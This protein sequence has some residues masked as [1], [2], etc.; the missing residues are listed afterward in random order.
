MEILHPSEDLLKLKKQ[1]TQRLQ[2]FPE[3]GSCTPIYKLPKYMEAVGTEKR[4][5]QTTET[6]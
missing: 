2:E 3:L 6:A 4:H 5:S 1:T